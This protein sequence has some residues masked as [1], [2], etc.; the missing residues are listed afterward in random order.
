MSE[1]T[2]IP[3][4]NKQEIE[5]ESNENTCSSCSS[6]SGCCGGFGI[7]AGSEKDVVLRNVFLYLAMG[8]IMF[9]VA[10]LV[11]RIVTWTNV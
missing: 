6:G 7:K 11:M 10:Y 8:T 1:R 3:L 5:A 9:T 4:L 2:T